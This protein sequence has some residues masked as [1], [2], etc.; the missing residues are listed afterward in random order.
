MA[1]RV[2]LVSINFALLFQ[3]HL[4]DP[5]R[6][7]WKSVSQTMSVSEICFTFF[8]VGRTMCLESEVVVITLEKLFKRRERVLGVNDFRRP[9]K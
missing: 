2:F 4:T 8:I 9:S 6:R 5:L 1:C 3:V 7:R